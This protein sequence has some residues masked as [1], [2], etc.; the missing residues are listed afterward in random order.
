M[1]STTIFYFFFFYTFYIK[2]FETDSGQTVRLCI[3]YCSPVLQMNVSKH[4]HG[5]CWT[6]IWN[7]GWR[8]FTDF[9]S[10][11][12]L[13]IIVIYLSTLFQSDKSQ[14]RRWG[15]M[16]KDTTVYILFNSHVTGQ[17]NNQMW[18]DLML[19]QKVMIKYLY[20]MVYALQS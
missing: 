6:A 13:C 19:G 14:C 18:T 11:D 12:R 7:N 3:W 20:D 10:I 4:T 17:N 15:N 9:T 2:I 1:Y 16:R 8:R 5:V